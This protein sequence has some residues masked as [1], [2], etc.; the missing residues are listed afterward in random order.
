M[1]VAKFILQ[2]IKTKK[3]YMNMINYKSFVS[4]K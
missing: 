3:T 4:Q 2:N 1:M